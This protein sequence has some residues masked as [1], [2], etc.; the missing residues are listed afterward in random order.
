MDALADRVS[1]TGPRKGATDVAV[2]DGSRGRP[3]GFGKRFAK[4]INCG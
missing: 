3:H 1:A 4:G 2:R